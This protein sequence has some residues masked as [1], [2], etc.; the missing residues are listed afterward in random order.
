MQLDSQEAKPLSRPRVSGI[1]IQGQGPLV[2]QVG[3][4]REHQPLLLPNKNLHLKST[5][6]SISSSWCK[7]EW[8]PQASQLPSLWLCLLHKKPIFP[9]EHHVLY[10]RVQA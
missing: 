6:F 7:K 3:G 1:I 2:G 5:L 4:L 8:L 9:R 10:F